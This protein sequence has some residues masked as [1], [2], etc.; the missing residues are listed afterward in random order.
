MPC[1]A[2]NE[3]NGKTLH[4]HRQTPEHLMMQ[5]A[6]LCFLLRILYRQAMNRPSKKW[7]Q[8]WQKTSAFINVS[9]P[10]TTEKIN[11]KKQRDYSKIA[12]LPTG[13][14]APLHTKS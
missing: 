2:N 13:K 1:S 10:Q 11:R 3:R 4:A 8:S 5:E 14:S 7:Q 9:L 12:R 6:L